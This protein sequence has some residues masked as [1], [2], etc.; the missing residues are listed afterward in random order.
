MS[1]AVAVTWYNLQL[2]YNSLFNAQFFQCLRIIHT[3]E[4]AAEGGAFRDIY[5]R[6]PTLGTHVLSIPSMQHIASGRRSHRCE[7]AD[8][9]PAVA[10]SWTCFTAASIWVAY[11]G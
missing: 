7:Q 11:A 5:W 3:T 4:K 9:L 1:T 8:Y 2:L 6:V 10:A